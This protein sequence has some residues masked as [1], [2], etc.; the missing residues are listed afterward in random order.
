[1]GSAHT[2]MKAHSN[3]PR[4]EYTAAISQ[5]PM[6]GSGGSLTSSHCLPGPGIAAT[7]VCCLSRT[8]KLPDSTMAR[9]SSVA[10]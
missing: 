1:M 3:R 10:P 8:K 6:S 7:K 2:S 9:S 4:A 5:G